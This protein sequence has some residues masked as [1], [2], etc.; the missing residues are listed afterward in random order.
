[1][2][3]S[4]RLYEQ[5]MTQ[6]RAQE[7]SSANLS[8]YVAAHNE[9]KANASSEPRIETLRRQ[10]QQAAIRAEIRADAQMEQSLADAAAVQRDRAQ[11]EALAQAIDAVKRDELRKEKDIQRIREESEE[12][13]VLEAKLKAAYVNKERE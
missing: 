2:S 10:K 3:A 1:M 6:R 13:R 12:L 11:E 4:R 7:A 8:R 9:M 5:R